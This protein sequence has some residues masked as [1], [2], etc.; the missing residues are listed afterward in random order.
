[1]IAISWMTI[2]AFPMH[3][4]SRYNNIC[5]CARI[6][7]PS[8]TLRDTGKRIIPTLVSVYTA[9]WFVSP[10]NKLYH[11]K[12]SLSGQNYDS[13]EYKISASRDIP[14]PIFFNILVSCRLFFLNSSIQTILVPC[15]AFDPF[16]FL[17]IRF[18]HCLTV[19]WFDIDR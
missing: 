2:A 11:N 4:S 7:H 5:N 13:V 15:A 19:Q 9:N 17:F 12:I 18:F 14:S 8:F 6:L 1:M 16:M 10:R 3:Q